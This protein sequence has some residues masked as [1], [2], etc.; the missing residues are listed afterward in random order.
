MKISQDR[1][2]PYPV[3]R[4]YNK[5][6]VSAEFESLVSYRHNE[7]E[8][9]FEIEIKLNEK[10]LLN[11]LNKGD[12]SIVCH[13]ECPHTKFRKILDMNRGTN[14]V[15]FK[16]DEVDGRLEM[17]A[18]IV[19]NKDLDSYNSAD[20][21][22]EYDNMSFKIKKSSILAIADMPSHIIENKKENNANLPSIF[23]ITYSLE[24]KIMRLSTSEQRIKIILPIEQYKIFEAHKNSI[25]SRNIMN[26]MI[27]LP[28]LVAIL[29]ELS[30]ENDPSRNGDFRWFKVIENK[31]KTLGYDIEK[32]DLEDERIF[33]IAQLMSETLFND[34][35]NS[36]SH[37]EANI[38]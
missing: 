20:F 31:L 4:K 35:I 16:A 26:A 6:F 22:P 38:E 12:V 2:F 9:E 27:V 37:S 24:D 14:N 13:F 10:N 5:N 28:V 33:N 1:L 29:N 19:S 11:L 32:G 8:H 3:L 30:H 15:K 34:G 17:V 25:Y 21:E 7:I 23:N 18:L 36:L